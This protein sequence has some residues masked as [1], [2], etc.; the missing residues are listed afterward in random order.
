VSTPLIILTIVGAWWL[1]LT[2]FVIW[3]YIQRVRDA[4][5]AG[6]LT[7]EQLEEC[8]QLEARLPR[9]HW[10]RRDY[11]TAG[12]FVA[13]FMLFLLPVYLYGWFLKHRDP[14]D[15]HHKA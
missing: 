14:Y 7:P 3:S 4:K 1:L 9:I 10:R 6:P 5:A 2:L 8:R 12:P 13:A 15:T 11:F